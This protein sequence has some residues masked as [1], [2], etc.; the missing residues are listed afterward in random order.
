[1]YLTKRQLFIITQSLNVLSKSLDT[2]DNGK[3]NNMISTLLKEVLDLKIII[4]RMSK[5]ETRII[6]MLQEGE[7]SKFT[8]IISL[9]E[10]KDKHIGKIGTPERDRYEKKLNKE[11]NQNKDD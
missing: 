6:E 7:N 11:L 5:K 9:D 10:L 8:T 1:M 2:I 4:N 3:T